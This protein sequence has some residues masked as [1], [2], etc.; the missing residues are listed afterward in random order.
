VTHP[1]AR[2]LA[3]LLPAM[4]TGG[5]VARWQHQRLQHKPSVTDAATGLA[6]GLV[7]AHLRH[8]LR[9]NDPT[10]LPR[11]IAEHER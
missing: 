11:T 7:T 5:L 1:L 8:R 2:R 3:A 6:I 10:A 9:R 4:A